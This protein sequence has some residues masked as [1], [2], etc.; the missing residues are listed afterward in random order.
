MNNQ[1]LYLAWLRTTAPT[2][3]INAVKRALGQTRSLGGLADDL[4]NKALAPDLAHSFL[5]D[6]TDITDES[7]LQDVSGSSSDLTTVPAF[8]TGSVSA[9]SAVNIASGTAVGLPSTPAATSSSSAGNIFASIITAVGSVGGAVINATNQSKL[10]ALNTQRASQGLPPINANGQVI[11]TTGL[12]AASPGLAAFENMFGSSGS[13][14]PILFL[15][16]GA[17]LLFMMLGKKS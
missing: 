16:G 17:I 5:G 3:Y 8:D 2:V 9:P 6:D 4:V 11:S 7:A 13:M 15:G 12:A 10:I 14:L 1:Q